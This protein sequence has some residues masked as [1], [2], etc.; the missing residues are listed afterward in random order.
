M[1][2]VKQSKSTTIV[3]SAVVFLCSQ[4]EPAQAAPAKT[5][6]ARVAK[7]SS[8]KLVVP[9]DVK[10]PTST[11]GLPDLWLAT[12]DGWKLSIESVSIH[13]DLRGGSQA[14]VD[15]TG[16]QDGMSFLGKE[17]TVAVRLAKGFR[18]YNGYITKVREGTGGNYS[19]TIEPWLVLLRKTASAAVFENESIP[20]AIS[21]V[22]NR[23]PLASFR[24]E[25]DRS[26]DK[27]NMVVQYRETDGNL[28]SRL[29]E[30]IGLITTVEHKANSHQVVFSDMQRKRPN[31]TLRLKVTAGPNSLTSWTLT[32][33]IAAT[34][35]ALT[36]HNHD[37]AP[38][39][40]KSG[41]KSRAN[42]AGMEVFDY[43][44][45][46]ASDSELRK[47]V[48]IRLEEMQ[49]RSVLVSG[50]T[51][52]RRL[53]AGDVIKLEGHASD[54]GAYLVT[55]L[56]SQY[57]KGGSTG[58]TRHIN[59]SAIP[60]STTFRPARRTAWPTIGGIQRAQVVTADGPK[61]RLRIRFAWDR[62]K[63]AASKGSAW[64]SLPPQLKAASFT[65][66]SWI[67]IAFSEGEPSLP[68]ALG[69]IPAASASPSATP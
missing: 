33:D 15:I 48:G 59:F 58:M 16:A 38:S 13:E 54:D 30:D 42:L 39:T 67:A 2:G 18:Y 57:Y 3:M 41:R 44:P 21:R 32:R 68:M 55:E 63:T 8:Q 12:A 22:M 35:Y 23:H 10:S 64:V 19:L 36:N 50:A 27:R 66:G 52:D 45:S 14:N 1:I 37:G 61:R 29:A 25:L 69:P 53:R 5:P 65:K 20:G 40:A 31:R 28:V 34:R 51:E 11:K 47:N 56:M 26:Y 62:S 46:T 6:R 49:A 4:F 60:A 43:E 9:R 17:A 24:F 7:K